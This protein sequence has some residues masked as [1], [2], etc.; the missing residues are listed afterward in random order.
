MKKDV[1]INDCGYEG[2]DAQSIFDAIKTEKKLLFFGPETDHPFGNGLRF[3]G[4]AFYNYHPE[5]LI[6]FLDSYMGGPS[7]AVVKK[8]EEKLVT[9]QKAEDHAVCQECGKPFAMSARSLGR[10]HPCAGTCGRILCGACTPKKVNG[11]KACLPCWAHDDVEKMNN[12]LPTAADIQAEKNFVETKLNFPRKNAD[13]RPPK[14]NMTGAEDASLHTQRVETVTTRIYDA[15]KMSPASRLENEGFQLTRHDTTVNF[16]SDEDIRKTYYKEMEDLV[17][18]M[19]GAERAILFDHTLRKVADATPFL[20]KGKA[21]APRGGHTSTAVNKVHGDY[22]ETGAPRR[23]DLMSKPVAAGSSATYDEPPL[24]PEEAEDI[25]NKRRYLIVNVW[26]NTSRAAPV[27]R[28]PLAYLDCTT[29]ND[30]KE[31]FVNELIFKDRVGEVLGLYEQSTHRWYFFPNMEFHEAALFKTF[32]SSAQPGRSRFTIH[33]AF[34]DPTTT[35]EDP[36]RESIEVRVLAIMPRSPEDE[37][38]QRKDSFVSTRGTATCTKCACTS[39]HAADV[40]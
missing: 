12:A 4:Y 37:T 29:V 34:E 15:R 33:S 6:E 30:D 1:Y 25:I 39:F 22:T 35:P 11:Q 36:T 5:P 13:G 24:T 38:S 9:T 17:C 26:R 23:V 21:T 20:G 3:E 32:D 8:S 18:K 31:L 27:T 7:P 10:K 16:D 2:N 14:V 28:A 40:Q 19:T